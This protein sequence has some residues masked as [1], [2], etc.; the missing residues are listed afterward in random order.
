MLQ[1]LDRPTGV[2]E[3]FR[4]SL[5]LGPLLWGPPTAIPGRLVDPGL[6]GGQDQTARKPTPLAL[7]LPRD[8]HKRAEVRPLPVQVRGIPRYDHRHDLHPSLAHR[9][10]DTKIPH[11]SKEFL[12]TTEHPSTALAGAVGTHVIAGEVGSPGKTLDALTPVASEVQ[13]VH[14]ERSPTPPS[15][16]VPAGD[17]DISWWM[18]RNHLLEGIPSGAPP[19]PQKKEPCLYSDASRSGW[20]AHLL[21]QSVSGLW[22]KRETSLHINIL[23]M[24]ALF[25][26]LQTFQDTITSQRVTAMCDNSTVVVYVN[27]RGDRIRLPLRADRATSPLDRSPQCAPGS[28]VPPGT[29]L[30]RRNQMLGA[31]LSLHPQV[32]KM[33][34]RKWGSPTIDLFATHLNAKLPL[35]CSLIPDPQAV[36][37][38]AFRHPWKD[39]DVYAFPPFHLV[40][41]VVARVRETPNLS[42][43]LVAPL[44]PDK[45]WFA[46]LLL[47][48]TQ[49]PLELPPWDHLRQPHFNQ[50]HGGAN[51]LNLHAWRLSSVSSES[52]DFRDKLRASCPV[53]SES[54][55]RLYQSQWLSFC[56]WCRGRGVTPIDA[57]I[58]IIGYCAIIN[59]V[60]TLKGIDLANSKELSMLFRSFAKSCS[61]QDLHPPAWDVALVLQSLTN[62]PYEPIREAEERFLAH[63]TLFL[64]ALASAKRVGELHALSYRVS[65]S[66]GW[67][68]VSFSFVP[69]FVAKTPKTSLPSIHGSRTSR[70]STKV[71]QLSKQK[72]PV[73]GASGQVLPKPHLPAS[74]VMRA[75]VRHL[76][77]HQE[78]L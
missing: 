47:L 66:E 8:S 70:C 45:T 51:A 55:A 14:R 49:P 7:P 71:E 41:R 46:N 5:N 36:F 40:E 48:L 28:K 77:T 50:F 37:E 20:G 76:G 74:P 43:T 15:T 62:Q 17:K 67:R 63:K 3:S 23:E 4:S 78:D 32:A 10:S 16:P 22:S 60:F 64:I 52:Q 61:P 19:P 24:K 13:L 33:I 25:L 68:E 1:T 56:G 57:T 18:V 54:T 21:D 73:S 59:S 42:M 34:I 58:P 35:Y 44:W 75:V 65:H 11:C 9:S 27:K 29:I 12:V 30:S 2:H 53:A 39:L 38:D 6:L 26:T 72:T 69:G 31:E